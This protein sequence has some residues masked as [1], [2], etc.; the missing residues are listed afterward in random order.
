MNMLHLPSPPQS[1]IPPLRPAP[2]PPS[3]SGAVLLTRDTY[4]GVG[5]TEGSSV[6]VGAE[7]LD[8]HLMEMK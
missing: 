6:G 4:T 2:L 8:K 1:H 7:L 5:W 3:S